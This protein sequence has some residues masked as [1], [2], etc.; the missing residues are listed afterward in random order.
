MCTNTDGK[1]GP[2]RTRPRWL[3]ELTATGG[4]GRSRPLAPL[5]RSDNGPG[6]TQPPCSGYDDCSHPPPPQPGARR[7]GPRGDPG[8]PPTRS[9]PRHACAQAPP[10]AGRGPAPSRRDAP[11]LYPTP[12]NPTTQGHAPHLATP[13]PVPSPQDAPARPR[14]A[15]ALPRCSAE[16]RARG[17]GTEDIGGPRIGGTGDGE[18]EGKGVRPP[19]ACLTVAQPFAFLPASSRRATA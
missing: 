16:A 8:P 18:G 4:T 11:P 19:A 13:P 6:V 10:T 15:R 7:R 3:R 12:H 2:S 5:R 17:L 14:L 9:R 1:L